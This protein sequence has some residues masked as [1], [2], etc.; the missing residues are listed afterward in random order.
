MSIQKKSYL[1]TFGYFISEMTLVASVWLCFRFGG[2][3]LSTQ[4]T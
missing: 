4:S 2:H 1:C 3:M